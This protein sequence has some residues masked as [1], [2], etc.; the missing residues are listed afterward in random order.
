MLRLSFFLVFFS[1]PALADFQTGNTLHDKCNGDLPFGHD[2]CLA[3]VAAIAD[4]LNVEG[5]SI[6]GF[7]A[8]PPAGITQGQVRDIVAAWLAR[9]PERRHYTANSLVAGA[10][11]ETFPCQ[12]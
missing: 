4:V 8:C 9:Y 1:T 6:S 10:I 5:Q 7:T 2:Y 12:Q 3:Y 11:S